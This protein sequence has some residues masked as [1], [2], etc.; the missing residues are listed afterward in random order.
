MADDEF[1]AY[2]NID[3]MTIPPSLNDELLQETL[4]LEKADSAMAFRT[5]KTH[6]IQ[7]R[8]AFE[9]HVRVFQYR[10]ILIII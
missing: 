6:H 10:T 7:R 3:T 9:R 1:M 2:N 8:E 4:R 5:L